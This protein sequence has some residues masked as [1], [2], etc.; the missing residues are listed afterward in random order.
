MKN[1]RLI[2]GTAL[3]CAGAWAQTPATSK[4][5]GK[6]TDDKGK[7]AG[8]VTLTATRIPDRTEGGPITSTATVS[9]SDGTY[10][11]TGLQAG[12][13]RLCP[14]S[15]GSDIIN[16]CQWSPTTGSLLTLA[17]GQTLTEHLVVQRG[18]RVKI[19]VDDTTGALADAEKTPGGGLIA[20]VFG[21]RGL[22]H[23][24][25]EAGKDS[26][27]RTLMLIVPPDIPVRLAVQGNKVQLDDEAGKPHK[28]GD[29]VQFTAGKNDVEKKFKF[30]TKK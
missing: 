24:A 13:Y 20:G 19:E 26:K 1:W 6:L 16:P 17:A 30:K 8:S 22:F 4:I 3:C 25:A 28:S 15:A 12:K 5:Q 18:V 14:Q 9:N 27:G 2:A 10:S 11:F 23:P 7:A 29:N 21:D